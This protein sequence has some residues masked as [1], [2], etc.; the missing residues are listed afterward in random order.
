[1]YNTLQATHSLTA[2]PCQLPH[3]RGN[4][5]TSAFQAHSLKNTLRQQCFNLTSPN[6]GRHQFLAEHASHASMREKQAYLQ[7]LRRS[8]SRKFRPQALIHPVRSNYADGTGNFIHYLEASN[9]SLVLHETDVH[10]NGPALRAHREIRP[11]PS[12]RQRTF[13][14]L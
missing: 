1:M 13:Y 8:T 11:K 6:L 10:F 2:L 14:Q 5:D 3:D 4:F 9:G 12:R 7:T